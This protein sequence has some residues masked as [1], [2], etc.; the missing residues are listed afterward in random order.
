MCCPDKPLAKDYLNLIDSFN[1]VQS[2]AGSTHEHGHTVDLVL[3]VDSLHIC[4]AVFS[5]HILFQHLPVWLPRLLLLSADM[6]LSPSL[7]PSF[8]LFSIM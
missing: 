4:D 2:V 5:D 7:L 1:L 6:C 3:S 8:R